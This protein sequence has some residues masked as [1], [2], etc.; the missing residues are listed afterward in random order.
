MVGT[1]GF[2]PAT[3][4]SRMQCSTRLSHVPTPLKYRLSALV[5]RDEFPEKR[6]SANTHLTGFRTTGLPLIL[7][8]QVLVRL[9]L[10]DNKFMLEILL[11]DSSGF[12]LNPAFQ[13]HFLDATQIED[14]EIVR[15][16]SGLVSRGR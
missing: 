2:E 13:P 1:T 8:S 4:A 9:A 12:F 14:F 15:I 11:A 10:S 7:E 6:S 16:P 3:P 5:S